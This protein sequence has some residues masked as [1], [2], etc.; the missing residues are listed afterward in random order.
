[1]YKNTQSRSRFV[2]YVFLLLTVSVSTLLLAAR[3]RAAFDPADD[4]VEA[5]AAER[6]LH[7]ER[8]HVDFHDVYTGGLSY[9]D[10]ASFK[11]FGTNLLAPRIMLLLFFTPAVAAIWYIAFMMLG[12]PAAFVVTLLAAVW[13]VPLYPSP[14][15]S[16]Y[17][18]FFAIFTTAAL[19][20]YVETHHRR[21]IFAAG[22]FAGIAILF[23]VTGLYTV[24]GGMLF[25]LFDEQS[26]QAADGKAR[27]SAF[28]VVVTALLLLFCCVL[29]LLVRGHPGSAEYYH[30]VLPGAVLSGLLIYREWQS[31]HSPSV[32]RVRALAGRMLPFL[33]GLFIPV[34]A[35]L[36][37]YIAAGQV[38]LLIQDVFVAPLARVHSAY[39]APINPSAV[40]LSLPVFGLVALDARLRGQK[41]R[42][43]AMAISCLGCVAAIYLS[44]R[45]PYFA[46]LTWLSAAASIPLLSVVAVVL[47]TRTRSGDKRT[48]RLLLLV[49][50]IAICS[51]NQYPFSAP[52][53][54]CYVAPL[55]ILAMAALVVIRPHPGPHIVAPVAV[56]FLV[57]AVAVL[58]PNQIYS[59]GLTLHPDVQKAFSIPRA[60]G[61][62][63]SI[64]VVE[65][66]E[67][68]CDEIAAHGGSVS[69]YAGP[70]SSG[71]YFLA[72]RKNPTPILF[73]FLAGEDDRPDRILANVDR[74]RVSVVVINHAIHIP[75][76]PMSPE[77]LAALRSRFPQS[78]TIDNFEIRWK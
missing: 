62:R 73:D 26:N 3:I 71:L 77:L 12:P 24:A 30:F 22:V 33:A 52:I 2:P 1:M 69:I 8:Q 72:D 51:L 13:S 5:H 78:K 68:V 19:F 39:W 7:G 53:Y 61:V 64:D 43:I 25:L 15:A 45:F 35:F 6:V 21:W 36:A 16:W 75:S 10:A 11:M 56:F 63:G 70:D 59:K 17:M 47:L 46:G 55:L 54:F 74:A 38:R 34:A 76:D 58:M 14:I 42:Q 29:G 4:P 18:L 57:F 66:Y 28:S 9:L 32:G 60:S 50:M 49:A 67:R 37:P 31:R 65:R 40:L 44:L 20:C 48:S 23:K 41:D 27:V